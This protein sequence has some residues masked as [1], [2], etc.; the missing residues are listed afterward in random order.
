MP[1]EEAPLAPSVETGVGW[2]TKAFKPH[3]GSVKTQA[4]LAWTFM[5]GDEYPVKFHG[6]VY[7]V[8]QGTW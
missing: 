8:H 7:H 2:V 3:Q 6:G 1:Y 4:S 5:L